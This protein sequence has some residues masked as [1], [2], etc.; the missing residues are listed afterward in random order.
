MDHLINEL[1]TRFDDASSQNIIELMGLLP[2]SI[3]SK[4]SAYCY[5]Q[6]DFANVLELYQDDLPSSISFET[7]ID[8]WQ[9]KW[10]SEPQLA[11]ELSTPEKALTNSDSDFFP[12][13][14]TL[15]KIMATLPVT[16][17][18]CERSF[19]MLK[20]VKS[21]LRSTMKQ[22]RLNGLAMLYYHQDIELSPEEVVDK[23][24]HCHKRRICL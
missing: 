21:P 12:N 1:N 22:D 11:I 13:I 7:E 15:L 20:L 6:K 23:F 17:C 4:G 9:C 3:L 24:A 18:E 2:S 10:K 19:S 16:S 14:H 8:L 5:S